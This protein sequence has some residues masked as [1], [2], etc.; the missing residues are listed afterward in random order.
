MGILDDAKGK[1]G[2]AAEWVK[3]KAEHLGEQAPGVGQSLG[4]K[5]ADARHWVGSKVGGETAPETH[6]GGGGTFSAP[7]QPSPAEEWVE[8][9]A[10]GSDDAG[11]DSLGSDELGSDEPSAAPWPDDDP[12][13]DRQV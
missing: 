4:E 10:A 3:D 2:D 11:S 6:A 7:E 9:T 5:V 12:E 8:V 13:Q 1:L